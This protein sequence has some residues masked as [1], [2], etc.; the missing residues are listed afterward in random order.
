MTKITT[1]NSNIEFLRI[2]AM[3]FI[4][5]DHYVSHGMYGLGS[6]VTGFWDRYVC[7]LTMLGKFGDTIFVLISGYYMCESR[8]TMRK[9]AR[10]WGEV[11]LYSVVIYGIFYG[12]G[13][14][15]YGTVLE[16]LNL[17][18]GKAELFEALAPI[19]H[20]SYWFATDYVLLMLVSPLLNQAVHA[21]HRRQ[22]QMG[23]IV[24]ILFWGAIP[25]L[26][27]AEYDVS[28]LGWFVVLYFIAAYIRLY[29][30]PENREGNCARNLVIAAVTFAVVI[31]AVEC[32]TVYGWDRTGNERF[33]TAGRAITGFMSPFTLLICIELFLAFAKMPPRYNRCVNT[34]ASATF[35]VYLIHNNHYVKP[36]L[37]KVI[38]GLPESVAGTGLLVPH[39]ILTV[40]MVYLV[41]T[42]IDL[43][44]QRTVEQW[45]MTTIDHLYPRIQSAYGALMDKA[46]TVMEWL[47][48]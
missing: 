7:E 43:L 12:M 24:A 11:A 47:E 35:G 22:L 26:T 4:V 40:A 23:I 2:L 6:E 27:D 1:R 14:C 15:G 10:L 29:A 39:M 31:V 44:R 20:S 42:G 46:I 41:C 16:S 5:M 38:L 36:Y 34:V 30:D 45:Y 3:L 8:F 37:W 17:Y 18:T 9:L 25:T 19:G 33:I 48:Q 13:L 32:I 21:L 28:N